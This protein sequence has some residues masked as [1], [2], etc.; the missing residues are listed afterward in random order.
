MR[1]VF[2]G[3]ITSIHFTTCAINIRAVHISSCALTRAITTSIS[4]Y[5]KILLLNP[6]KKMNRE[7]KLSFERVNSKIFASYQTAKKER[8]TA[9]KERY[10]QSHSNT[11]HAFKESLRSCLVAHKSFCDLGSRKQLGVFVL[12]TGRIPI[13]L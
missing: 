13:P 12:S 4:L 11:L 1:L 8:K 6:K 3:R 2:A 7:R 5:V 9:T 10:T